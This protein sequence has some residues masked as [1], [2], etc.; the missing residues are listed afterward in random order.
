[1]GAKIVKS[2]LQKGMAGSKS[3]SGREGCLK[4]L[5]KQPYL[6]RHQIIFSVNQNSGGNIV[7]ALI[8]A[9]SVIATGTAIVLR[10]QGS[11]LGSFFS[12]ESKE[13]R[14]AA[15]FGHQ[16]IIS[17]MA[18]TPNRGLLLGRF[19]TTGNLLAPNSWAGTSG[20]PAANPCA[21]SKVGVND[22]VQIYP[23]SIQ[24]V[25]DSVKA[26]VKNQTDKSY[27]LRSVEF[28]NEAVAGSRSSIKFSRNSV[29][30]AWSSSTSGSYSAES[31]NLQSPTK[32]YIELEVQ[33]ESLQ[34]GKT[35]IS[36]IRKEYEVV[37]KCCGRSFGYTY[38]NLTAPVASYGQDLRSCP[39]IGQGI[40][41]L[42][43][44][45]NGDG[46][47]TTNG[48]SF[49]LWESS[50]GTN[51]DQAVTLNP[52]DVRALDSNTNLLGSTQELPPQIELPPGASLVNSGCITEGITLPQSGLPGSGLDEA[53]SGSTTTSVQAIYQQQN[54]SATPNYTGKGKNRVLTSYSGCKTSEF[55]VS[56][57]TA[58][59]IPGG[60]IL[61]DSNQVNLSSQTPIASKCYL[62]TTRTLTTP[63]PYCIEPTS[64][65]Y[66]CIVRYV[67]ISG[68]GNLKIDT[69]GGK[70]VTLL[71]TDGAR[72]GTG[73]SAVL[74]ATASFTGSGGFAHISD[75]GNPAPLSDAFRFRVVNDVIGSDFQLKGASGA[76]S[77]FFDLR[78]S[79]VSL[80]GGGAN[81]NI[82]LSGILWANNLQLNGNAT[83]VNPPSGNCSDPSPAAGSTCALLKALYPG[84][85][86][87]D[88]TND[89]IVPANDWTPRSV[90]SLNM[91][92]ENP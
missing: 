12:S 20:S 76:L 48:K 49:D 66:Y 34:D 91:Y 60:G 15:L 38:A 27:W 56:P 39:A 30:S 1:M 2:S 71:F 17:E 21:I 10:S 8:L 43:T 64:K 81:T 51:Q 26:T 59:A 65:D 82:N 84:L 28:K 53:C 29:A 7:L 92:Q 19:T 45:A 24:G 3:Y 46:T 37:P 31:V 77:G 73:G 5:P 44:G 87:D 41:N 83:L 52:N 61:T 14:E 79:D 36:R 40:L 75:G 6:M 88:P 18:R 68:G 25:T 78:Y 50:I 35:S 86:D 55:S 72:T 32:A 74:G 54:G 69:T 58:P 13:S 90:F 62:S 33:G 57:N 4:I 67:D 85:F 23:T 47:F 9:A 80:S 70:T 16:N 63:N 22:G 42:V 89:V 11:Y